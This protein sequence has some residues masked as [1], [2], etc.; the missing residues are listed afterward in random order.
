[1]D[2][3]QKEAEIDNFMHFQKNAIGKRTYP[4]NDRYHLSNRGHV[5]DRQLKE[6]VRPIMRSGG[7]CMRLKDENNK[8]LYTNVLTMVAETFLAEGKRVIS[9]K[10]KD[11]NRL[12]THISNL[13]VKTVEVEEEDLLIEYQNTVR[14]P[15]NF[16]NKPDITEREIEFNI[17]R[18]LNWQPNPKFFSWLC[19]GTNQNFIP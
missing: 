9:V 7:F 15:L 18:K 6:W 16:Y 19:A 1:M 12:N 13:I 4:Y 10:T 5:Y 17:E 3:K 11:G 8:N 14:E 2:S